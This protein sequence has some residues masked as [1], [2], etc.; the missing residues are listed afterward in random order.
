MHDFIGQIPYKHIRRSRVRNWFRGVHLRL[1]F[2]TDRD[3]A[4]GQ[5][6]ALARVAVEVGILRK[7]YRR[8]YIKTFLNDR[9]AFLTARS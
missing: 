7:R 3:P 6:C 9:L 4:Y 8:L 1:H 2:G 5:N